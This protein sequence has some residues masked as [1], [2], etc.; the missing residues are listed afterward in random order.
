MGYKQKIKHL[1]V[2]RLVKTNVSPYELRFVVVGIFALIVLWILY[3]TTHYIGLKCYE[4]GLSHFIGS[5]ISFLGYNDGKWHNGRLI[6]VG[7]RFNVDA[8]PG[9]FDLYIHYDYSSSS[10]LGGVHTT[11]H[12]FDVMRKL[13]LHATPVKH[14][15]E[16]EY[17]FQGQPYL[18]P[19]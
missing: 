3:I 9:L 8:G 12:F 11:V 19:S 2:G 14:T 1:L 13:R 5:E 16:K 7:V 18:S 4:K 10:E 17:S 15:N 6:S